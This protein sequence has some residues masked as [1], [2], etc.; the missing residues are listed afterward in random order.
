MSLSA[1]AIAQ[2]LQGKPAGKGKW[3]ALCPAHEDHNPSL[4]ITESPTGRTL[5]RCWAGCTQEAVIEALRGRWLW[6]DRPWSPRSASLVHASPFDRLIRQVLEF[7]AEGPALDADEQLREL[8]RLLADAEYAGA[9]VPYMVAGQI[10]EDAATVSYNCVCRVAAELEG[11][12][13]QAK[14]HV[15]RWL[16]ERYP[17]AL[18]ELPA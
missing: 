12:G 6:A 2:A 18:F 13:P 7:L 3:K 17:D 4:S 16:N 5:F 10:L 14:R 11:H 9:E 1:Q 15:Q 8:D